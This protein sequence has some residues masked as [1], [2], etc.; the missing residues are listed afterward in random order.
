MVQLMERDID[1]LV[2]SGD[3]FH[4]VQP[5]ARCLKMYYDFLARCS[6]ETKLRQIIITAGNHDSASRLDAPHPILAQLGIHIVGTISREKET[7]DRALCP[8]LTPDGHVE[9]VIVGVPYIHESRLGVI[10]TGRNPR[11]I[12]DDLVQ[13]FSALYLGLT[14]YAMQKYPNVPRIATGHLTC[15]PD[16]R[17]AVDGDFA[18]PL[19]MVE[20]GSM[21]P[22]IFGLGY[23]YVAL[24]HI[25]RMFDIP[26]PN[27]WYPGS[28][29]PTDIIEART[30]R[31]VLQVDVNPE[32]PDA[33]AQVTKIE[34]P[35]W[36]AIFE[37]VGTP[38]EI[39]AKLDTL[40]WTQDLAPYLYLDM[41]VDAPLHNGLRPIEERI[42]AFGKNR[43]MPRIIKYKETIVRTQ[44][45]ELALGAFAHTPLS[46]LDPADV[47]EKMFM[48]K[49]DMPPDETIMAAFESL[50]HEDNS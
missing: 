48:L 32:H 2:H 35:C 33:Q 49:H 10:T 28:P 6:R 23:S 39:T 50:L 14:E 40:E 1:V 44:E 37:L 3:T 31:H 47:F 45:E 20:L 21:P 26:G 34:V 43:R 15:Y 12:R 17:G 8:I 27:A 38:D 4:Y 25:H 13:K 29:V 16:G 5:S 24:G 7:W 9:S 41:L 11:E 46:D 19:H 18:T 36:R 42:E 22:T 30:P